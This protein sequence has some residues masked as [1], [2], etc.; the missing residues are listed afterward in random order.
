[1][2]KAYSLD[3]LNLRELR[4]SIIAIISY[5]ALLSLEIVLMAILA[6][7]IVGAASSGLSVFFMVF[8]IQIS[9]NFVCALVYR[10][11]SE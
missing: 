7:F 4:P 6:S 9:F 8:F 1:M 11:T 10:T 3:P 2:M 5:C